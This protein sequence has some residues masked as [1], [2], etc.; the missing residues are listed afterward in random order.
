MTRKAVVKIYKTTSFLDYFEYELRAYWWS[1]DVVYSQK[2]DILFCVKFFS[3]IDCDS[4]RTVCVNSEQ[5]ECEALRLNCFL[6]DKKFLIF[7]LGKAKDVLRKLINRAYMHVLCIFFDFAVYQ[8][9]CILASQREIEDITNW[10]VIFFAL[11][12]AFFVK[13]KE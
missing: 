1:R 8:P 10:T 6:F 2:L 11:N 3:M 12:R 13:G 4:V 7:K 9:Q 5:I